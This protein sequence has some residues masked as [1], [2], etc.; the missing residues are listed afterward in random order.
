MYQ[1]SEP[2]NNWRHPSMTG[3]KGDRIDRASRVTKLNFVPQTFVHRNSYLLRRLLCEE[4]NPDQVE[5]G[6]QH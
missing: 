6:Y 5:C 4:T 3:S 1:L 2:G